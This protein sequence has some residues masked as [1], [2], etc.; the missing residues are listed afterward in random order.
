MKQ[1]LSLFLCL[2]M[3][4]GTV[5]LFSSCNREKIKTVEVDLTDY[6]LVRGESLAD[7]GLFD[8]F[9]AFTTSLKNTTGLVKKFAT[10]SAVETNVSEKE[11]LIGDTRRAESK[12]A[13][14]EIEGHGYIIKV[15]EAKIAIVGSTDY[16]TLVA[17]QQ[18]VRQYL[19]E[20]DGT[21]TTL[22]LA[23]KTL[24]SNMAMLQLNEGE[25]FRY[26]LVYDDYIDDDSGN[27]PEFYGPGNKGTN[28]NQVDF[29]VHC[30]YRI[31][32]LFVDNYGCKKKS[33]SYITDADDV[34]E[35]EFQI[36]IL[37]RENA[38]ANLS[39][40]ALNEFGLFT[41][42]K[43]IML[44]SWSESTLDEA[45]DLLCR[46]LELCTVTE[47]ESK[48][49]YLPPNIA[50]IHT[51]DE[52][53]YLDLPLPEADGL[54]LLEYVD[55]Y[56]DSYAYIYTGD[57]ATVANYT[58]YCK[59]LTEQGYALKYENAVEGSIFRTYINENRHMALHVAFAAYAHADEYRGVQSI[60][61]DKPAG[62]GVY[63]DWP[64]AIRVTATPTAGAVQT[65]LDDTLL[66]KNQPYTKITDSMITS[67]NQKAGGTNADAT[68]SACGYV[69]TLEDGSFFICDGGSTGGGIEIYTLLEKLFVKIHG[70][71]P[72]KDNPIVIAGY[73]LT[74][75]HGDHTGKM[76]TFAQRYGNSDKVKM[77][78][79]FTNCPSKDEQFNIGASGATASY[80]SLLYGFANTAKIVKVRS[81]DRFYLR[82]VEFEVLYTH[83]D[84]HPH[85]LDY[86]NETSVVIR[87]FVGNSE[88]AA[89]VEPT[90]FLMT[91][92]MNRYTGY[93]LCG[94]YGDYLKSDQMTVAHHGWAGPYE[95]FYEAVDPTVLWWP[96]SAYWVSRMIQGKAQGDWVQSHVDGYIAQRL[97]S[98]RYILVSDIE[99]Q[100]LV[101]TKQGPDYDNLQKDM[102][103]AENGEPVQF[104][105]YINYKK[106]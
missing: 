81:G 79:F 89:K 26:T 95:M 96:N 57:G 8:Y 87:A 91:G 66:N 37:S 74:H 34:A 41:D 61:K 64:V 42:D 51:S 12:E 25:T 5:L 101:I 46:V 45:Y 88:A 15:T 24:C 100:T 31:G 63:P 92:D 69:I 76:K 19:G 102:F 11:I 94:M 56:D 60:F 52:P 22:A 33:V 70:E 9:T 85:M 44:L 59:T 6:A 20:S 1:L 78:Y 54:S 98:V 48:I 103:N 97:A 28:P 84:M 32:D 2:S 53:V 86:F 39:S 3:L 90:S 73:Y 16:L 99:S 72:S 82:N 58:A 71:K 104:D 80:Q 23:E 10:D 47:G 21:G 18:F 36:G 35:R 38:K 13:K 83:E 62:G 4:L 29:A 17:L 14:S 40:L 75:L 106:R 67:V 30:C 43:N 68:G 77:E 49:C 93:Y 27:C 7:S 105:G 55:V 65:Y 50:D